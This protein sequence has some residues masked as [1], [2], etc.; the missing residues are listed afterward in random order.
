MVEDETA[1]RDQAIQ[2]LQSYGYQVLTATNGVEALEVAEQYKGPIHLLLSDVMMPHLSGVELEEKLRSQR[3]EMQVTF[4]SGYTP[5]TIARHGMFDGDV[6]L[7]PKLFSLE[8]LV[9]KV[10]TVLAEGVGPETRG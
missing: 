7:L 6:A 9:H 8:N 5:S 4:M 3:P 2:V 1:V 10:R